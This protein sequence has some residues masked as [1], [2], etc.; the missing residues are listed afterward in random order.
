MELY[1]VPQY[2]KQDKTFEVYHWWY[3]PEKFAKDSVL[4]LDYNYVPWPR[5]NGNLLWQ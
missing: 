3:S 5:H 4:K 1:L 2:N